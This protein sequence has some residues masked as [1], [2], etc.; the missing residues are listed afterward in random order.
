MA[1][2]AAPVLIESARAFVD[3][4]K[5]LCFYTALKKMIRAPFKENLC[6]SYPTLTLIVIAYHYC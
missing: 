2:V 3:F 5:V 6:H 1:V 4:L